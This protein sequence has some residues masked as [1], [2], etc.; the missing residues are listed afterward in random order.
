MSNKFLFKIK[1]IINRLASQRIEHLKK[2]DGL[3]NGFSSILI[4]R[5]IA[6]KLELNGFIELL[7]IQNNT[8][9][10][11]NS[12]KGTIIIA[13]RISEPF[14]VNKTV[15]YHEHEI[16]FMDSVKKITLLSDSTVEA[17]LHN[18]AKDYSVDYVVQCIDRCLED[19][20]EIKDELI[21][22][23]QEKNKREQEWRR[24][25]R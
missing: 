6:K 12:L 7:S 2:R 8:S 25:E 3:N 14:R 21:K 23:N 15:S 18:S 10:V 4:E 1:K 11:D 13:K 24:I 5:G 20:I 19:C 22:G 17:Y 9:Q 16:C